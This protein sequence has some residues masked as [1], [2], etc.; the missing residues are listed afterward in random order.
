MQVEQRCRNLPD[1][2]LH[3][4]QLSSQTRN[5]PLYILDLPPSLAIYPLPF[6]VVLQPRHFL[7][8][9]LHQRGHLVQ[10][11]INE[12][13]LIELEVLPVDLLLDGPLGLQLPNSPGNFLALSLHVHHL[14]PQPFLLLKQP[15]QAGAVLL[16]RIVGQSVDL[17]LKDS[18][19]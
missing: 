12:H 8:L 9:V 10:L 18:E 1:I 4:G 6:A 17:R 2:F 15:R 13:F 14:R 5:P 11:P 7:L 19:L 3:A 16:R